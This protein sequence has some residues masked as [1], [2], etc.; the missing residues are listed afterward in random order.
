MHVPK[1]PWPAH[2]PAKSQGAVPRAL[3][4]GAAS[5]T[6]GDYT[7]ARSVRIA[8]FSMSWVGTGQSGFVGPA[9]TV[10]FSLGGC[11]PQQLLKRLYECII[12]PLH[13]IIEAS[14]AAF[15]G[16]S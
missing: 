15:N 10:A 16:E 6:S 1:V 13:H 7:A 4:L 9:L 14:L 2:A 8:T 11:L 12:A 3:V 5:A